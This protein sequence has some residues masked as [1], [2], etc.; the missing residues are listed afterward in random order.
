MH[1]PAC[2]LLAA[3]LLVAGGG[4]AEAVCVDVDTDGDGVCDIIDNCPLD[5]NAD[6]SD[7]DADLA[8][9][10]CDPVDGVITQPKVALRTQT[11]AIRGQ[12]KGLVLTTPPVSF[13]AVLTSVGIAMHGARP[14]QSGSS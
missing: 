5:A 4:A 3:V 7:V 13:F 1:F 11:L 9:D 8:G 2:L 10:V 12:A 14:D 6:Q